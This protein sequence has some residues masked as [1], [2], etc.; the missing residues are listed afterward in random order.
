MCWRRTHRLGRGHLLIQK[1]GQFIATIDHRPQRLLRD[2]RRSIGIVAGHLFQNTGDL[3]STRM[4]LGEQRLAI[5][6]FAAFACHCGNQLLA[7]DLFVPTGQHL[8]WT[9]RA[10]KQPIPNHTSGIDVIDKTRSRG[11]DDVLRLIGRRLRDHSRCPLARPGKIAKLHVGRGLF[12]P[13]RAGMDVP[14]HQLGLVQNGHS[15]QNLVEQRQ[16]IVHRLRIKLTGKGLVRTSQHRDGRCLLEITA[17]QNPLGRLDQ[18]VGDLLDLLKAFR[19][20]VAHLVILRHGICRCVDIDRCA[21][22]LANSGQDRAIANRGL[23]GHAIEVLFQGIE[24][25]RIHRSIDLF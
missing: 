9:I 8:L 25:A 16:T 2:I 21:V 13:E 1:L 10:Q 11:A 19:D 5:R 20:G 7:A 4:P 24:D 22:L 23:G 17:H 6:R 14:V 18:G 15:R 3:I 12:A